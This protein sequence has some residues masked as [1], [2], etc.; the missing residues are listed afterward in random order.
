MNRR[1]SKLVPRSA[2]AV[3]VLLG[4]LGLVTYRQGRALE[5]LAELDRI[6]TD[7]G[8]MVAERADLERR[9]QMLESRSRVVPEARRR[10]D[11]KTPDATEIVYLPGEAP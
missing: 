10:L 8:V 7:H 4:S 3:V 1:P 2:V 9:V 5:A 6:R 11:M